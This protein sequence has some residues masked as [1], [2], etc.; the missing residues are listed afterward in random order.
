[1]VNK[2][3]EYPSLNSYYEYLEND[4]I[5]RST[6]FVIDKNLNDP[7]L[8]NNFLEQKQTLKPKKLIGATVHRHFDRVLYIWSEARFIHIIRDPRD[9]ARSC[10]GMGW[11][12]NVWYGIDR[13]IET[14]KLWDKLKQKI[15]TDRYIEIHYENLISE[16]VK[17]LTFICEFLNFAYDSSMLNYD[18]N[19]TYS[20]PDPKLIK[21]WKTKL[22]DS[23]IQLIESK[24]GDLLTQKQYQPSGLPKIEIDKLTQNKSIDLV[25]G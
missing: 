22:S 16:P 7:E 17:N 20:K 13:W 1:M 19:S 23:Q 2:K 8:V 18:Q 9:V 3:S 15:S 11:A 21:Q 14:E 25:S 6:G 4:R 12:G 5:F 10:I 24:I